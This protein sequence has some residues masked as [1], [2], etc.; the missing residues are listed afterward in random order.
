MKTNRSK[1]ICLEQLRKALGDIVR[2]DEIS[3]LIDT[4]IIKIYLVVAATAETAVFLLL[5]FQSQ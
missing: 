5:L 2:L 1:A 4:H 3:N